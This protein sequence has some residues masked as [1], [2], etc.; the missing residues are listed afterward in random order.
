MSRSATGIQPARVLLALV[1]ALV[2]C[3]TG[4]TEATSPVPG[5]TTAVASP[6]LVDTGDVAGFP[7]TTIAFDDQE[8]IVAVADTPGRRSQGLRG[9]ERF[10]D[11]AGMLFRF[12]GPV[13]AVF[14]MQDTPTPLDLF[15]LDADGTVLEILAMDPCTGPD[16]RFP[17]TVLYHYA[18][19]VPR[20]SL[21]A[22]VGDRL[23]LP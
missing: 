17:P 14:T 7:T 5:S 6:A 21:G 3:T 20:M 10:G 15:L 9:V 18:L 23:T 13:T 1:V 16:C 4:T 12:D 19:E 11:L 2:A 8:L 22:S